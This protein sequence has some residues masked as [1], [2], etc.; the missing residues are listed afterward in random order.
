MVRRIAWFLLIGWTTSCSTCDAGDAAVDASLVEAPVDAPPALLA[1]GTV[2]APDATWGRVQRG[3][4]GMMALMVPTAGG[5]VASVVGADPGL[6]AEVD[7]R[8]AAYIVV[9]E[10]SGAPSVALALRLRNVARARET[11]SGDAGRH[12]LV[13]D[14][15]GLSVY[16]PID[17]SRAALGI[18]RSGWLVVGR[19]REDVVELGPYAYRTLP[20]RP[21]P[22]TNAHFEV[23]HDAFS[24]FGSR[25]LR[26]RWAE[27]RALLLSKDAEQRQAH[28]GREPDFGD[29]GA[30]VGLLDAWIRGRVDALADVDRA[31][32]DVDVAADDVRV[33]LALVPGAG[34]SKALL[35]GMAAGDLGVVGPVP[36]DTLALA[37]TRE[38]LAGR[39]QNAHDVARG[40]A[41]VL[42]KRLP[43]TAA[44]QL[45]GAL[46][47]FAQSRGDWL[48]VGVTKRGLVL[49]VAAPDAAAAA[50]A[51]RGIVLLADTPALRLPLAGL[52]GVKTVTVAEALFPPVGKGALASIARD[53]AIGPSFL[54]PK[55]ALGWVG[56]DG[57]L[58]AALGGD[59]N[60]ILTNAQI[61]ERPARELAALGPDAAFAIAGRFV[62][63]DLPSVL[64]VLRRDGKAVVV[65]HASFAFVRAG[66]EL[67]QRGL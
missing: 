39:E 35:D 64:A 66:V 60:D 22:K 15:G 10:V 36:W 18:A 16:E 9:A 21:L 2:P 63:A 57:R 13:S 43:P 40:L 19:T 14:G 32:L 1:E 12:R 38:G 37:V 54:A 17:P 52:A 47:H 62:P 42:G 45:D 23:R 27:A 11:L 28:G 49:R 3:M 8:A 20:A 41:T 65:V 67:A 61:D 24:R 7:G 46:V 51:T 58:D 30:I 33:M 53:S 26:E 34:P 31:E 59:A 44:T 50:S 4:G 48:A 29:A 5:L 56:H 55:L 6:G 25:V